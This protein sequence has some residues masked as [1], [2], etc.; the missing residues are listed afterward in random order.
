[1]AAG[2]EMQHPPHAIGLKHS[3]QNS[4]I[5]PDHP[6]KGEYDWINPDHH[7]PRRRCRSDSTITNNISTKTAAAEDH[8]AAP[9]TAGVTNAPPATARKSGLKSSK[10]IRQAPE[11]IRTADVL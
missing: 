5:Q 3:E 7:E 8:A 2:L 11:I 10:A 9:V 4:L 1:M 6:L